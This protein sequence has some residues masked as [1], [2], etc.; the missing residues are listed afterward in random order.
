M[1][2]SSLSSASMCSMLGSEWKK[3]H[4]SGNAESLRIKARFVDIKHHE[5]IKGFQKYRKYSEKIVRLLSLRNDLFNLFF[6]VSPGV[7]WNRGEN[8]QKILLLIK[9]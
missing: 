1:N 2:G 5:K 7:I 4:G 3:T 9:L 6:V 8:A